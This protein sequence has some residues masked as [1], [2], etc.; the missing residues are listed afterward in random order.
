[1]QASRRISL[2]GWLLLAGCQQEYD[3]TPRP[4]EVDPGSVT[5]CDFTRVGDTDFYEYDCNPVFTT[6][7]EDWAPD[8]GTTAFAVTEVLGH[9]FYQ[10]WYQGVTDEDFGD[11]GLGYAVSAE[12]T[13]WDPSPANPLLTES[14]EDAF[15]TSTMDSLQVVWDPETDQYVMLYQ[16]IN[17]PQNIWGLGVATSPDGQDWTRLADNPILDLT[18][19]SGNVVGYCWP[20]G[21]TLREGSGFEGYIAGYDRDGGPCQV[22]KIDADNVRDWAP[23]DVPVLPA[24][25]SGEWDDQGTISLAIASLS[26]SRYMFYVGFG[27][28]EEHPGYRNSSAMYLGWATSFDGQWIKA[29]D[30]LPLNRTEAGEIS[31]VAAV[32]IGDR[33]H[34]WIT[35]DYDGVQAV[36]YFLYDPTRD[37]EKGGVS[38]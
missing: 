18:A 28:W 5:D 4:P 34:L 15:D 3:V 36:G 22:Y 37:D 19:P 9:P 35:D 8:I 31:A 12:G 14:D 6:T 11:Y 27:D 10:M 33:I 21:L 23:G 17:I 16:G 24:G 26:D 32:A 7:G 20:L 1:M 30:P 29:R 25:E 2:W 38:R 13:D